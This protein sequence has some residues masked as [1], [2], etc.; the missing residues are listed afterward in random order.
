MLS[1]QNSQYGISSEQSKVPQFSGHLADWQKYATEFRMHMASRGVKVPTGLPPYGP[2]CEVKRESYATDIAELILLTD[3]TITAT[4]IALGYK[5]GECNL[6]LA[7]HRVCSEACEAMALRRDN[8]VERLY[9]GMPVNTLAYNRIV[10]GFAAK[11]F[12]IMWGSLNECFASNSMAIL[13]A[14]CLAYVE[15]IRAGP[16]VLSRVNKEIKDKL[17]LILNN[18]FV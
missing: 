16:G 9:A 10:A 13:F 11:D 8:C 15:F 18:D 5:V 14:H 4:Q 1:T 12:L 17:L 2:F 3:M 6:S 7:N